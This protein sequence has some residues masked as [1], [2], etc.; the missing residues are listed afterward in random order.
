MFLELR[1]TARYHGNTLLYEPNL[2]V[3]KSPTLIKFELNNH[4]VNGHPLP[5]EVGRKTKLS[6]ALCLPPYACHSEWHL[7]SWGVGSI[8]LPPPRLVS[9][10]MCSNTRSC[11]TFSWNSSAFIRGN[12]HGSSQVTIISHTDG[13]K[14]SDTHS[15]SVGLSFCK[16]KS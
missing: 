8:L 10:D 13:E 12:C 7:F 9:S 5:E 16:F 1:Q 11:N 6:T 15:S 4:Q 14:Q 2:N 3:H